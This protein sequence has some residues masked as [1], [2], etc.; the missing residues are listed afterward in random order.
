MYLVR[1]LGRSGELDWNIP[2]VSFEILHLDSLA[3]VSA[4]EGLESGW[5]GTGEHAMEIAHGG[6]NARW[7]ILE[8]HEWL[9]VQRPRT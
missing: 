1:A 9:T 5:H 6:Q 2:V 4:M 8:F 3:K 7:G